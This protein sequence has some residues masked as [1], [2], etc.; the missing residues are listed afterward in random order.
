M[1]ALHVLVELDCLMSYG[2]EDTDTVQADVGYQGKL[3]VVS[4][5]RNCMYKEIAQRVRIRRVVRGALVQ[6]SSV[7][8]SAV[9]V[10]HL[11]SSERAQSVTCSCF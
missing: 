4:S 6:V 2:V 9:A 8:Q 5:Y 1:C 3:S 11:G 7:L 10:S